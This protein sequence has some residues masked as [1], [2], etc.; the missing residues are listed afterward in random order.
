MTKNQTIMCQ[1][2]NIHENEIKT[3]QQRKRKNKTIQNKIKQNKTKQKKNKKNE[4][5]THKDNTENKITKILGGYS[6]YKSQS[7]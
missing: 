7:K 1:K 3:T 4:H 6:V 2:S 5:W